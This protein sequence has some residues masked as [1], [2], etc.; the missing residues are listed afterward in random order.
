MKKTEASFRGGGGGLSCV[1]CRCW[2][3]AQEAAVRGASD[4]PFGRSPVSGPA[5][6]FSRMG[7][8][9]AARP[10]PSVSR[11]G[12]AAASNHQPCFFALCGPSMPMLSFV[13]RHCCLSLFSLPEA[14]FVCSLESEDLISAPLSPRLPG[15]SCSRPPGLPQ[16]NAL[17]A[18]VSN[19]FQLQ[20]PHETIPNS[21]FLP[22]VDLTS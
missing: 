13:Y 22:G 15:A 14:D 6:R 8:A 1:P 11:R 5:N 16:S 18:L 4:G 20:L 21:Y 7:T 3:C 17:R 12:C 9:H 2:P 10:T 19:H